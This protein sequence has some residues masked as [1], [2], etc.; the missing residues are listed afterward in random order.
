M[1]QVAFKGMIDLLV[2]GKLEFADI[3][4]TTCLS[5]SKIIQ[6]TTNALEQDKPVETHAPADKSPVAA[7]APEIDLKE[8]LACDW[9]TFDKKDFKAA[10]QAMGKFKKLNAESGK[11]FLV[12]KFGITESDLIP[13]ARR[14][15]VMHAMAELA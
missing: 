7:P 3:N 13:I 15:E 4:A 14:N 2:A 8:I 11:A 12:D 9:S 6:T 10:L 1:A 5:L